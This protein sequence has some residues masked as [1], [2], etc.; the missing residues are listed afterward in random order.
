[1]EHLVCLSSV[2]LIYILKFQTVYF[3][4]GN[5]MKL[6]FSPE[7]QGALIKTLIEALK[8]ANARAVIDTKGLTWNG[9]ETEKNSHPHV[10]FVDSVPYSWL[11]PQCSDAIINGDATL[12]NTALLHGLPVFAVN[13]PFILRH[14]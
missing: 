11:F 8:Q 1:M 13:I 9:F 5:M 10:Y 14:S 2:V 12:T 3:G 4:L 7:A 6:T